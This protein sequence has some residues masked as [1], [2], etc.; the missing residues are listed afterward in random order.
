MRSFVAITLA[1]TI[2]NDPASRP[3]RPRPETGRKRAKPSLTG[4][5][6]LRLPWSIGHLGPERREDTAP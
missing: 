1:Y 4:S 3:Y 5:E 6:T 2:E